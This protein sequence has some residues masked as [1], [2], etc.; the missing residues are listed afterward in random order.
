[1]LFSKLEAASDKTPFGDI[2]HGD[3]IKIQ[4]AVVKNADVRRKSFH[5]FRK[6]SDSELKDAGVVSELRAD[7]LGHKSDN[8]TEAI[9][10]GG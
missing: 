4:T 1:M 9:R 10:I 6:M 8:I 5:S 3:R 2:F 7:I